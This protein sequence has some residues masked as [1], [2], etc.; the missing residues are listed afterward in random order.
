MKVTSARRGNPTSDVEV[1]NIGSRGFWLILDGREL[2]CAFKDFPWFK[3]APVEQILNV[4]RPSQHHLFW[5][6]LDVD[7]T[8][9]SIEHPDQYP[10][11]S[12][13]PAESRKKLAAKER[14]R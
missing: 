2:F 10:L 8:T 6:D 4:R 11:V 1:T 5:P 12:E 13:A 7:L 9:E 14:A 3:K